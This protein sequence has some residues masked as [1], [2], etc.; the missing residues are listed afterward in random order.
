MKHQKA[1]PN[2]NPYIR[3]ILVLLLIPYISLGQTEIKYKVFYSEN[4]ETEGLKIQ[5]AFTSKQAA[6]STYFHYSDRVWG[7]TDLTNCFKLIQK[8][9]PKYTF[10]IEADSNRIVV[11][12][13]KS[14]NICFSYH[15]IQ[16]FKIENPKPRSR[17]LL[18]PTYFH[19]LGESLFTIPE[20]IIEEDVNDPQMVVSIEWLDFPKDFM[21]HNTFGSMKSK[22]TLQVKLWSELYHSIFVGGDYRIKSF[23]Y[24]EKPVHLA[25][26]GEWLGK[27]TDSNLFGAL[28]KTISTQ[29]TFWKDNEFDYYTVVVTPTVTQTDSLYRRQNITGTR[30]H[31][32]F[33]IQSSNNPFNHFPT[34][35]YMF[36]H[37][38]MHDWIGGKISMQNEEL[39]YWFSEGFTEYYTYKNGLRSNTITLTEFLQQFNQEVLK[40][41]WENPERNQPNYVVK[42]SFWNNKNVEKIPYRRGAIFA[43]WLDNQI[44]KKSNHAKSLDN[45]MRDILTICSTQNKKFTDGLFLEIAKEYLTKDITYFFQKHIINGVDILLKNEDLIQGFEIENTEGV[46]K[47]LIRK[48][49]K[50]NYILK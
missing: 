42:D 50:D 2:K 14:K 37:E 45:M 26:R 15:I 22:Q 20:E 46:P 40:A 44:L 16:D 1:M 8:E 9:N 21:I 12:H 49:T 28:K 31:N 17:P 25:I 4:L 11:Y 18:Q 39:N 10:K 5:V 29:R 48:G 27:Y 33:L 41:H 36:N 13:P 35:K 24:L 7:E 47:I 32:G 6:D 43:F 30:I 38:M 34:L 19:I 23:R 3:L